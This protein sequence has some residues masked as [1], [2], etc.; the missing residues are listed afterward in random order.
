MRKNTEEYDAKIHTFL[1]GVKR[2]PQTLE[3]YCTMYLYHV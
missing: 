1:L 3:F 2:A